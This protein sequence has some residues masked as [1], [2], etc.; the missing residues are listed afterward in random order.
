MIL[1]VKHLGA[2]SRHHGIPE[3]KIMAYFTTDG[4]FPKKHKNLLFHKPSLACSSTPQNNEKPGQR[5]QKRERAQK[6]KCIA[7]GVRRRVTFNLSQVGCG[8]QL[9]LQFLFKLISRRYRAQG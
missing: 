6:D 1:L 8:E 5:Q 2:G 3:P 4:P 7:E 9:P